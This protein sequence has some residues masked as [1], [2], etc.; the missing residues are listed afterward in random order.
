MTEHYACA[1]H[2]NLSSGFY[3]MCPLHAAAPAMLEAL[4]EASND[5]AAFKSEHYFSAWLKE[6][7]AA[8][9]AAKGQ[10]NG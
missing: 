7:R 9:R 1:C 10:R 4:E 6:A 5:P 2:M 8:I 3:V